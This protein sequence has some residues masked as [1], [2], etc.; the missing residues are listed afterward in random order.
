M[1]LFIFKLQ[2]LVQ[3][4]RRRNEKLHKIVIPYKEFEYKGL[5]DLYSRPNKQALLY[6]DKMWKRRAEGS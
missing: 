2:I 1:Y 4:V 3:P 6:C 5:E